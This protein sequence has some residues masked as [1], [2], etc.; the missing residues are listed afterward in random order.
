MIEIQKLTH[1]YNSRTAVKSL[2]LRIEPG[3]IFGLIGPNGAGKTTA[4]RLC[5]A[6]LPPQ[7]GRILIDGVDVADDPL[8]ARRLVGYAPEDAALYEILTPREY[9]QLVLE[10][11]G[12]DR[13][14][15]A[16]RID[17]WLR[18]LDLFGHRDQRLSA[19]SKGTKR[20]VILI[21]ALLHEPP[22]LLLDEPLDGLDPRAVR[23]FKDILSER[24]A[25]GTTIIYSS[26]ILEV[27]ERLCTRI[28]ILHR[29]SL[30]AQGSPQALLERYRAPGLE[31]LFLELTGAA[32]P[33]S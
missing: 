11:R 19:C 32:P 22:V 18:R 20:K 9:L 8:A 12:I 6:L 29:G 26:H 10:L 21:Q 23:I 28:G 7:E 24:A 14:G 1:A 27:V 2:T 16:D 3:E 25:A 31:P 33:T 17:T 13:A 15:A 30:R 4:L 5:A